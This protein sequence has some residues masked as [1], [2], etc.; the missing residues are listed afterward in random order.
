[1]K[2]RIAIVDGVRTPFCK[3]GTSLARVQA[4]DLGAFIVKELMSRTGFPSAKIDELIFGNVGSPAHAANIARVVAL[5]AGLAQDL[6]AYSVHRNCASGMESITTATNKILSGN[7]NVILAGGT[8]SMSNYPLLFG[9]KMTALFGKLMRAKTLGQKISTMSS[10][11]PSFLKPKI[12]VMMGLTD[13]VCGLNMGQTAEVLAREFAISRE[14]QDQF[15]LNSHIKAAQAQDLLA[16]EIAPFPVPPGYQKIIDT[17]NS[18]RP[19][20]SLEA[21]G[22][23]KPYFDRVNGTVTA[24]NACPLTDGAG[25]VLLMK[26]S[27]AKEMGLDVLGYLK[28]YAYAGLEPD[29]MGLGPVYATS[30]VLD[31]AGMKM[32]DMGLV[33]MNEAFAAQI[34]ANLRAFESDAFAK[35]YLAKDKALGEIDLTKF[36]IYGGAIAIGHPVGVTGTRLVL[37][38]LKQMKREK[39]Q[40]GLATLC[41]GGGQGAALILEAE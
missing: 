30:K 25:A 41:I 23:L 7:A 19:D 36:N 32:S 10:F 37:S 18:V 16:S 31:K 15:A 6:I 39:V 29:R 21:L 12:T 13:P 20:Q 1:M 4:D 33:E 17:D 35:K 24:A 27:Q 40:T 2:E 9:D 28:E 11:R 3:A 5:K 38:L 26:E 14:E 22:K 8:E 34:I